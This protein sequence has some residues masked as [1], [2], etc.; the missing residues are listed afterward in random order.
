ASGLALAQTNIIRSLVKKEGVETAQKRPDFVRRF[1]R[2]YRKGSL[3]M[4][5]S[6]EK[7]AELA[8]RHAIDGQDVKRNLEIIK[9][10]N[11]STV[12][13]GTKKHGLGWFDMDVL[14]RVDPTPDPFFVCSRGS[15]DPGPS[16]WRGP[17][18]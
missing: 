3:W 4:L 2:A 12:S 11:A 18:R 6:P 9:I 14:R 1:L 16:A 5:D 8:V 7:A 17:R 13:E 15:A 10:R